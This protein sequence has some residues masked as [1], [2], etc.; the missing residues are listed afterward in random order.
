M[1]AYF[2]PLLNETFETAGAK[3][4]SK[5]GTAVGVANGKER[6]IVQLVAFWR[7]GK[8]ALNYS[9]S[10]RS[11]LSFGVKVDPLFGCRINL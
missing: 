5:S 3:T 10:R 1:D 7:N 8:D 2:F 9:V 4:L 6:L 11:G